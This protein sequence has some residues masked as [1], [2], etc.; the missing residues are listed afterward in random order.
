MIGVEQHRLR[1]FVSPALWSGSLQRP[2]HPVIL[3]PAHAAAAGPGLSL[4][5]GGA[6]VLSPRPGRCHRGGRAAV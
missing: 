2:V 3:S 4:R 6:A 1:R 5:E